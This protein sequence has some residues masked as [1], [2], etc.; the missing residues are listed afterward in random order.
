MDLYEVA[1]YP[2]GSFVADAEA[3]RGFTLRM[4]GKDRRVMIIVLCMLAVFLVSGLFGILG[5]PIV[6]VAG[7]GL[8]FILLVPFAF[9]VLYRPTPDCP[10]CGDRMKKDWAMLKDDTLGEFAICPMCRIYI[11]MHRTRK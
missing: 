6:I 1:E 8:M 3:Q 2:D 7:I 9:L 5:L 10:R 4:K 11:Y